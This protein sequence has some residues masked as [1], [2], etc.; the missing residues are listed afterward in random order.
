MLEDI[1][2]SMCEKKMRKDEFD[3]D[4][5]FEKVEKMNEYL[6]KAI[7]KGEVDMSEF[8]EKSMEAAMEMMEDKG[9]KK[10]M[11]YKMMEEMMDDDDA[12]EM[13]KKVSF[14]LGCGGLGRWKVSL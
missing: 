6:M 10:K 5:Y 3:L 11:M 7:M 14:G 8:M 2:E 12:E 4:E 9:G 1:K 13:M